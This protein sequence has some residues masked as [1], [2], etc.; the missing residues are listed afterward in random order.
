MAKKAWRF[1]DS[2][3]LFVVVRLSRLSVS[4][5]VLRPLRR[6]RGILHCKHCAECAFMEQLYK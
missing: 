1:L 4:R 3:L 2:V 5:E 6:L